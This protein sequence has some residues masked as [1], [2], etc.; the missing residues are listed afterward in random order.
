[1][2]ERERMEALALDAGGQIVCA[3]TSDEELALDSRADREAFL[4]LYDRYVARV[5]RYIAVRIG[6]A[7]VEDLV[8]TTF[9]RALARMHTYRPQ[10]GTFAAWLFAIAHNAV[11]DRHRAAGRV[12]ELDASLQVISS[13]PGP[14]VLAEEHERARHVRRLLEQLP[15]D[16]RDALALRYGGGLRFSEVGRSLGRSE[17]AAKMLVQRGLAAMRAAMHEEDR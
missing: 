4:I 6:S 1:V 7:E 15:P 16:Q 17:S 11:V 13:E 3:A 12:V 2:E 10:R 14:E 9:E 8:G 5:E